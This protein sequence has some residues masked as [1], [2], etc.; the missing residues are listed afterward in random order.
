MLIFFKNLLIQW[1]EAS[2]FTNS[3]VYIFVG[4]IGMN[5]I[6]ELIIDIV[7]SPVIVRI[8]SVLKKNR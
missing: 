1:G 7:L 8:I 5:F 4:L 3:F 2:G 6:V